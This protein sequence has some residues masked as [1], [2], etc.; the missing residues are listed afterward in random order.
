MCKSMN[1]KEIERDVL[2]NADQNLETVDKL[3]QTIKEHIRH[4]N[5][6]RIK[7]ELFN[8]MPNF[9]IHVVN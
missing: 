7:M 3:K 1:I 8:D 6:D 5:N 4:Y 2:D 9:R